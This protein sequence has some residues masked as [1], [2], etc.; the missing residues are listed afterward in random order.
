MPE[1]C[2]VIGLCCPPA[3]RRTKIA[4]WFTSM[5]VSA[6]DALTHADDMILRIDADPFVVQMQAMFRKSHGA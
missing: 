5:G 2:C 4:A 1:F 6:E 3:Q